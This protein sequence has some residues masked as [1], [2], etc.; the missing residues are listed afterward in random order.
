MSLTERTPMTPEAAAAQ[1]VARFALDTMDDAEFEVWRS[2]DPAHAIAFNRA[3]A[4]YEAF[5]GQGNLASVPSSRRGFMRAAGGGA[6]VMALGAGGLAT[7]AYAW[8]SASAPIGGHRKLGLPDGSIAAINTDSCLAWRFSENERTL[9]VERGEVAIDLCPGA[10]AILH[11]R[12]Q[13]VAL[14]PGRFNARLRGDTLDLLVLRGQARAG[15]QP[16]KAFQSLLLSPDRPPLRR[17]SAAQVEAVI[18]WQQGEILFD[19]ATLGLAVEEY[20]RFLT[21]KII[22]VDPELATIPVGGR[23]T[24]NDPA[25]FLDAV[26]MGLGI[27]VS[28]SEKAYLL[29]R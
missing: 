2:A 15:R 27:H 6:F 14:L 10:R 29:T 1:W 13:Q 3:M 16:V 9:W 4:A 8:S 22:I 25:A 7:R 18:A 20:N 23:F 19:E 24:S 28:V 21:R 11:G 17:L 12:D 5:E 26:S